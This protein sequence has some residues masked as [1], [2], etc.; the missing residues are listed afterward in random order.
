MLYTPR[1]KSPT[2]DSVISAIPTGILIMRGP[3]KK[4]VGL[5]GFP[6]QQK[7]SHRVFALAWVFPP[8]CLRAG[9]YPTALLPIA[10]RRE[11]RPKAE[12]TKLLK[13]AIPIKQAPRRPRPSGMIGPW[14]SRSS[15]TRT[16]SRRTAATSIASR[17]PRRSHN[18]NDDDMGGCV[19]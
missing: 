5:A 15:A 10:V 18:R 7:F 9:E 12:F 14:K 8:G 2:R 17:P 16:G 6:R 1:R 19:G 11:L 13:Q 3:K 4:L